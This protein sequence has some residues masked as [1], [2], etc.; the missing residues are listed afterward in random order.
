VPARF[1]V[2][3]SRKVVRSF[4]TKCRSESRVAGYFR[5][6]ASHSVKIM[7]VSKKKTHFR[8]FRRAVDSDSAR[9]LATYHY[10]A[11][12]PALLLDLL[13]ARSIHVV[14]LAVVCGPGL[15]SFSKRHK[16]ALVDRSAAVLASVCLF[17]R[18]FIFRCRRE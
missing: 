8:C 12:V 2:C 4:I 7:S 15:E 13:C 14:C 17:I 11:A 6:K 3:R 10:T 1:S 9:R 18:V 16:R 5:I